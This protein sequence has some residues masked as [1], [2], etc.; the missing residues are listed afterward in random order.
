MLP[1]VQFGAVGNAGGKSAAARLVKMA[2]AQGITLA[3]AASIVATADRN[4]EDYFRR[5]HN[6]IDE[7]PTRDDVVVNTDVL[8]AE[9]ADV[10]VCA[11]RARS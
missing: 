6:V 11:A 3:A 7:L 9:A 1:V 2:A 8:T 10:I 4:R 5:F